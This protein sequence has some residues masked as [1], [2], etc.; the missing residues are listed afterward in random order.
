MFVLLLFFLANEEILGQYAKEGFEQDD[1]LETSKGSILGQ[2][3]L[4]PD[5][6]DAICL[7]NSEPEAYNKARTVVRINLGNGIYCSGWLIGAE[8]HILTNEH[9]VSN[10]SQ[11]NNLPIEIMVEATSCNTGECDGISTCNGT[12][13]ATS[14]TVIKSSYNL[15][16]T[17]LK[18][19]DNVT[20]DYGFLQLRKAGAVLHE[21]IYIPQHPNGWGKKIAFS[22]TNSNNPNGYVRVH[23]LNE[24][25]CDG[26]PGPDLGYFASTSGGSSGSP[27]IAYSDHEVVGLHH[28]SQTSGPAKAIPIEDIISDLGSDLPSNS[29][30]C[31]PLH[32]VVL[33]VLDG[34]FDRRESSDIL[35]ATNTIFSG[36]EGEYT[37]FNVVNLKPGFHARAGSAFRAYSESCSPSTT[38][39]EDQNI[40]QNDR[41]TQSQKN[42]VLQIVPNPVSD[43]FAILSKRNMKS[44]ELTNQFGNIRANGTFSSHSPNKTEFNASLLPVG[45][46]FLKVVFSNGEILQKKVIKE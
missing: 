30:R 21:Q 25:G 17:L 22:S 24:S 39:G 10:Q 8:G 37:A 44:W 5:W 29:I 31:I 20:K 40:V 1:R 45:V 18:I 13:I 4:M 28:C 38:K 32:D 2:D 7:L 14:A 23:S 36:G 46:Y 11:A 41:E 26:L 9:C 42:Q 19:A 35:N 27:V 16:Y 12:Q 15:D 43:N 6:E 33:D 3:M 34:F